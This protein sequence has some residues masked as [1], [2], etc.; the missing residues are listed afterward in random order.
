MVAVKAGPLASIT[1]SIQKLSTELLAMCCATKSPKSET[2]QSEAAKLEGALD[3][4]QKALH[5]QQ[6]EV[7]HTVVD[8]IE[9]PTR[10]YLLEAK[11]VLANTKA[12]LASNTSMCEV[13]GRPD[14][15]N[16]ETEFEQDGIEKAATAVR[17]CYTHISQTLNLLK[18]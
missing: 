7:Q 16:R 11:K 13:V 10:G 4:L 15:E 1:T 12:E 9:S 2:L 17:M 5:P 3:E 6:L 14:L 8:D 18:E